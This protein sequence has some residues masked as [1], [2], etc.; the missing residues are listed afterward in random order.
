MQHRPILIMAG[1]TGGHIYPA[2][3]VAECLRQK[4]IPLLWLGTK[5]GLEAELVPQQGYQL[6]TINI[7]G[8]RGNGVM[9]WLSAPVSICMAIVQSVVV[10]MNHRPGVVLGMGG[11][12][13]GPGGVA[14]WLLRIPLCIHEQNA[15]AGLTNRLLKPLARR[16]M[17]AFPHTFT[18]SNKTSVTG[19]PVR[20]EIIAIE[21]PEQRFSERSDN[22]LRILVVGGS[23]GAK[24]L[25]EVVPTALAVLGAEINYQLKH[26]TGQKHLD[27][28][29][30]IYKS[31]NLP[32]EPQAYIDDMAAEYAWADI[33]ICR[34]GAMTVAEIAAAGVAAILVPYPY[35]VDDHQTANAHYLSD[36]GAAILMQETELNAQALARLLKDFSQN[37][38]KLLQMASISR[39]LAMPEATQQVADICM[40]VAYA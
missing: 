10:L 17:Q 13:S 20:Q 26:Q 16:V 18:S 7:S 11:F 37:R 31:L 39:S 9:R 22:V 2:L 29:K 30:A 25:N 36:A 14:A 28:S 12:A 5:Q 23:L 8:L 4:G 34:S 40:E 38:D 24:G 21:M 15:V 6:L 32:V 1:G 19:N 35:A 27:A 3:A 33:V